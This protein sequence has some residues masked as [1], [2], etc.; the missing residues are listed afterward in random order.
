MQCFW[1]ETRVINLSS[2]ERLPL[3][4][5]AESGFVQQ[6]VLLTAPGFPWSSW[7]SPS[8]SF[9]T[10]P[11]LS[12]HRHQHLGHSIIH[13][14]RNHLRIF[15]HTSAIFLF[16]FF[17]P[18]SSHFEEPVSTTR[19]RQMT[20]RWQYSTNLPRYSSAVTCRHKNIFF[21]A[22]LFLKWNHFGQ[23]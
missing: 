16:C 13:H 6:E 10:S 5:K 21:S 4:S 19:R 2:P 20:L 22:V 14:I 7:S 11:P 23:Y 8:P 9:S 15:C 1:C 18:F 17:I 3:Q 12:H